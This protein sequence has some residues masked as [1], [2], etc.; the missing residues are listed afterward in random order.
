MCIIPSLE[1]TQQYTF[2][3]SSATCSITEVTHSDDDDD[4]FCD[5]EKT[6][7]P[8]NLCNIP[9]RRIYSAPTTGEQKD[10]YGKSNTIF[11]PSFHQDLI[12]CNGELT[13]TRKPFP[14][15]RRSKTQSLSCATTLNDRF[16]GIRELDEGTRRMLEVDILK[17]LSVF[18]LMT[19]E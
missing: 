15:P 19:H 9:R 12:N 2:I 7:V 18:D 8:D 4:V 17:P 13:A 11:P 16:K 1:Q 5:F 10:S 3:S 6:V 14:L